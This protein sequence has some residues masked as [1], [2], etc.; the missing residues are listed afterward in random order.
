[1]N[2]NEIK[3]SVRD[4]Q[5]NVFP[6]INYGT[7]LLWI[8]KGILIPN[9][10]HKTHQGPDPIILL[11]K[12]D[13]VTIAILHGLLRFGVGYKDI[14]GAPNPNRL[15][16]KSVVMELDASALM[17]GPMAIPP[18]ITLES[19]RQIQEFLLNNDYDVIVCWAPEVEVQESAIYV[20]PTSFKIEHELKTKSITDLRH[21]P[22]GTIFIYAKQW[23]CYVEKKLKA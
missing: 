3:I 19:G 1:M 9:T 15:I 13:L 14:G 8:K 16:Y 21:C 23:E 22:F 18:T 6:F 4:A 20:Y 5:K 12:A 7:I 10:R 2:T 17:R 11:D